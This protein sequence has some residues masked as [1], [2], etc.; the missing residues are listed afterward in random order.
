MTLLVHSIESFSTL[1]GPGIRYVVFL[2][3]CSFRCS[4]CHNP[5][6]WLKEGGKKLESSDIAWEIERNVEYLRPNRGGVTVSG[7]DPME[8]PLA[9]KSL[10]DEVS[11]LSISRCIDTAG[12]R[13]DDE[14]RSLL[15]STDIV[16]L[17]MKQ[18]IESRHKILTGKTNETVLSFQDYLDEKNIAYRLRVT[19]VDNVNNDDESLEAI[20]RRSENRNSLEYVDVLPYH[21]LGVHKWEMLNLKY[22][23]K[24]NEPISTERAM[25]VERYLNS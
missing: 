3:G 10:F 12:Y 16:L 21:T 1:D 25:E 19:L 20:K 7:G 13:L 9:V 5:D 14:I 2:Q 6:T 18:A 11:H 17:D 8:Q 4:Y 15:E 23:L 24:E 22:T